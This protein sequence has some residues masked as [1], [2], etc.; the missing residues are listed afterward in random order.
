VRPTAD[1]DMMLTCSGGALQDTQSPDAAV[2][3]VTRSACHD[4]TEA[5]WSILLTPEK[6]GV[7][8]VPGTASQARAGSGMTDSLVHSRCPRTEA[9]RSSLLTAAQGP[10]GALG[11]FRFEAVS[12]THGAIDGATAPSSL[13]H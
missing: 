2:R 6:D 4:P 5:G 12:L 9:K 10:T 11:A 7:L 13:L 3:A 1:D 8:C